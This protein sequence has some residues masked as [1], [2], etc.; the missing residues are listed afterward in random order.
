M[1]VKAELGHWPLVLPSLD[2]RETLYSW[3]ATVHRRS[4]S[5]N[6]ILTSGRL[7]G[8]NHAGLL[9]DFPARLR[10]LTLRTEGRLGT[11]RELA[12]K[13]TLLGYFLP[14]GFPKSA[15]ALLAAVAS[16]AV[17][18]IKMRLGIPASGIG[19]Y[20]PM[21]W[22]ADCARRDRQDIGWPRWYVDQQSPSTLVCTEHQ[23]PL[24]QTW[25]PIS[26]VHRREWLV[27]DGLC[28]EHRQEVRVRDDKTLA[29]L[30]RLAT[31]SAGVFQHEPGKLDPEATTKI[32]RSWAVSHDAISQGGSVRHVAVQAQLQPPFEL[33][34]QVFA[35]LG[36]VSCRL[37]LEGII[38]SVMRSTPRPI[39]PAKH[40]VL[41]ALMFDQQAAL[42]EIVVSA[43]SSAGDS[44]NL[45]RTVVAEHNKRQE[46]N[47]RR[48][49][50]LELMNAGH[51][52]R[53]AAID[54]GVSPNT[55]V[56]WASQAGI[57][58]TARAKAL[59]GEVLAS[60]EARL[61]NGADRREVASR[62][63]ASLTS[64]NRLLST[65]HHLRD[66][67]AKARHELARERHRAAI[68]TAYAREP[69]CAQREL[70]S[71]EGASWTWLYRHDREWLMA[72]APSLWS[73]TT[74]KSEP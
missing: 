8:S 68:Q 15:E 69:Q 45:P 72:S 19:G 42:Q 73:R 11:P 66:E 10:D 59:K 2:P 38:S 49:A 61:R 64:V 36:P 74:R 43:D 56:R 27:P 67:W 44:Q 22:C 39:H 5:G 48:T 32:Y 13:H 26:P 47:A 28:N 4:V 23:R 31:L 53:R 41:M 17:P 57:K 46:L 20:H 71:L 51:S 52:V 54:A 33:V 50:F 60:I 1:E 29:I 25:H 40:L 12:L 35:D 24:I 3:C 21:R 16:G 7:F 18:D 70:R 55:G 30:L 34:S 14:F 6:A 58:F 62:H 65:D 9:H 37:S 63:G